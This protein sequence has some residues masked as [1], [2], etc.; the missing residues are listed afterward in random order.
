MLCV[1]IE[2]AKTLAKKFVVK[3]LNPLPEE[4]VYTSWK[5]IRK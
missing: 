3:S 2:I 1:E 5:D 4:L